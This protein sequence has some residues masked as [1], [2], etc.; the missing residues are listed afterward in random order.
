MPSD[1]T[2]AAR[3]DQLLSA[4]T[5]GERFLRALALSAYVRG[6]VWQGA[7]S[8]AAPDGPAAVRDRFLRQVYGDDIAQQVNARLAVNGAL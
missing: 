5:P 8:V 4:L 7:A 6:L 1:T 3:Y 2:S